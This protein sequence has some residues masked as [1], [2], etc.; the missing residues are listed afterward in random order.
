MLLGQSYWLF[1]VPLVV[2][3]PKDSTAL[4]WLVSADAHSDICFS[5]WQIMSRE[6]SQNFPSI[7]KE[8]GVDIQF[9]D[10]TVVGNKLHLDLDHVAL[11]Q[12]QSRSITLHLSR[13]TDVYSDVVNLAL[14]SQ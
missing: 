11:G 9:I 12:H 3:A 5:S 13:F 10:N 1:R 7:R 2:V 14:N 8:I 6:L 4:H